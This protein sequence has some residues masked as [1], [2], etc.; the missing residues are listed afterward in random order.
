MKTRVSGVGAG[1]GGGGEGL[2]MIVEAEVRRWRREHL[3]C[4]RGGKGAGDEV[5]L[6][7][8]IGYG[9]EGREISKILV[10]SPRNPYRFKRNVSLVMSE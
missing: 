2:D 8:V 4:G 7:Q 5:G 6:E 1:G 3:P 9:G 10:C